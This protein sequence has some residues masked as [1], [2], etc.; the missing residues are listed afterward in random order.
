MVSAV[1]FCIAYVIVDVLC[2]ILTVIVAG[3][4]S[5]DSGSEMQVRFF[6]L[7]L[8][9]FVVF[10][11]FDAIWAVLVFGQVFE[12]SPPL[13]GIVNGINVTSVALSGYFWLCF[14]LA[15]FESQ[16]TDRPAL[17]ILCGLPVLAVVPLHVVGHF[18]N[19]N[20]IF[21]PDGSISYGIVHVMVTLVPLLYIMAATVVALNRYRH[22]TSR[23]E[24][25]TC[26]VFVLFML[27][28]LVAGIT[29]IFVPDMPVAAAGA[30]VSII[31]VI[32]HMQESRISNDALTGLNNRRRADAYLE[33]AIARSS[34]ERPVFFFIV[35]MDR[36]KNI[37]DT[38]GHLEGDRA[39]QMMANALRKACSL[40]NVFAARWGGDEFVL[41]GAL[42]PTQDPEQ[43]EGIIQEALDA[44]TRSA[45]V[46]Y[47]LACSVGY[48]RCVSAA[49]NR[50]RLVADADEMLYEKKKQ[51]KSSR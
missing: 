7:L 20:V 6:F 23:G 40:L 14:C 3:N 21:G 22:S 43:V 4:V 1:D 26:L 46:A 51:K 10:V 31:F 15:H 17:R 19:Q 18:T 39:L 50:D 16:I 29:D 45:R 36:F 34:E 35:D 44:E 27:A 47:R 33:D 41:I 5:R 2:L 11:T 42:A 48:A 8:T 13:L 49:T 38:Y 24:R 30:M 9:A 25:R 32:M 12:A 37:N 28:P